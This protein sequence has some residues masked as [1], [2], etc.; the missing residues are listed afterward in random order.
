MGKT[1]VPAPQAARVPSSGESI[2]RVGL[3]TWRTF[4]V[5]H[6]RVR[7]ARLAE[8]LRAL[9]AGGGSV[10]DTSPMYGTSPAVLGDLVAET[11][12]RD[13]LFLATKVWTSGDA[14]GRDQIDG[15][16]G[17]LRAERI[18][19]LQVHNLS[20]WRTQL[21]TLRKLREAGR[22]RYVGITH[23]LQS[24]RNE[25]A[26]AIRSE[27]LDF[28]QYPLSLE[29]PAAGGDFLKLC[30]DRGVAFIANR[31]FGEGGALSRVR[32][33]PLPSWAGELGIES[34]AQYLLKW[35]L[36]HPEVTCAIPG[37]SNPAHMAEN[38]SAAH[39]APLDSAS[40]DRLAAH[41]RSL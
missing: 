1:L 34:W 2:P 38:L 26:R 28:V 16:F 10:V 35:I 21:A 23:Y 31:P 15:Q 11:G 5:G 19:L 41:W 22:I 40:R 12:L 37:T 6:D 3:G 17:A 32:G 7:R 9:V 20:D 29:E 39:G 8:V 24:A 4:D 14:R 13:R 25:M 18:E 30:G 33:T 36:S 27:K